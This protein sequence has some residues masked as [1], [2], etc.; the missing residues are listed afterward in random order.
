MYIVQYDKVVDCNLLTYRY[1][2]YCNIDWYD[3]RLDALFIAS[4]EH[5]HGLGECKI[6]C[7]AAY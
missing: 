2:S 7:H 1:Y 6:V 3:T 5:E 4:V